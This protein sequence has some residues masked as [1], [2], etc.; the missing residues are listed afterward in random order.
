MADNQT[1]ATL[2]LSH[3]RSFLRSF[4]DLFDLFAPTRDY[5]GGTAEEIS[6]AAWTETGRAMQQ[7]IDEVRGARHD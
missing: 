1:A 5:S 7:A 2:A 6:T 3:I 4:V